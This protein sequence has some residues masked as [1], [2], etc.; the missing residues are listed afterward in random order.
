MENSSLRGDSVV[1]ADDAVHDGSKGS[2]QAQFCTAAKF[3]LQCGQNGEIA[4]GR[5]KFRRR[6]PA[7]PRACPHF[8]PSEKSRKPPSILLRRSIYPLCPFWGVSSLNWP[9]LSGRGL[10]SM[11]GPRPGAVL[12]V[13][14]TVRRPVPRSGLGD[15]QTSRFDLTAIGA[16]T[17]AGDLWIR[18]PGTASYRSTASPSKKPVPPWARRPTGAWTR[19]PDRRRFDHRGDRTGR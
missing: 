2:Q 4:G 10:F 6:F 14:E 16:R 5:S 18:R 15:E 11:G 7:P 8:G 13:A 12:P 3:M 9:R 19:R 17:R 1:A